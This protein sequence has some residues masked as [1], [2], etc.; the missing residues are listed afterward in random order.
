MGGRDHLR[1]ALIG[2]Y[3]SQVAGGKRYDLATQGR[4]R[5][6]ATYFESHATDAAESLWFAMDLT[7]LVRDPGLDIRDFVLAPI[8]DFRRDVAAGLARL[9]PDGR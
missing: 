2:I 9:L 1:A 7:P 8:D 6:N 3:D 5:A 4:A